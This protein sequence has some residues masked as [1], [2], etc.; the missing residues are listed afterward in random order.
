MRAP[1]PP[2]GSQLAGPPAPPPGK[3]ASGLRQ[4]Y[5]GAGRG[6]HPGPASTP[7][8][9]DCGRAS[10]LTR[11][12]RYQESGF[13]SPPVQGAEWRSCPWKESGSPALAP[14]SCNLELLPPSRGWYRYTGGCGTVGASLKHKTGAK[15]CWQ[16]ARFNSEK[17]ETLSELL[18][19]L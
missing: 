6:S 3:V 16:H 1:E 11:P 9:C 5:L 14:T 15:S 13:S 2:V 12:G 18:T 10:V 8:G 17:A 19:I 7:S 4:G